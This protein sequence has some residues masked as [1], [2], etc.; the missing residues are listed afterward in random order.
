[1]KVVL[2]SA[3]FADRMEGKG[4]W[5]RG[6]WPARWI[7]CPTVGGP[8]ETPPPFVVAFRRRFTLG[9]T[10][11]VR[12]HV[13]ADERYE[14]FV[15]GERLGRGPERG[16]P[17]F[18]YFE[19]YDI[20]LNPGAH[21]IVARVWA[22]GEGKMPVAQFSCRPGAFLLAAEGDEGIVA[23]LATGV[24]DWE[25]LPVPGYTFPH[26]ICAWGTGYNAE[27]DGARYPWGLEMGACGGWQGAVALHDAE[28]ALYRNDRIPR[29]GLRPAPLPAPLAEVRQIGT[30]RLVVAVDQETTASLPIRAIDN[31][32]AEQTDWQNLLTPPP[33]P[34]EGD[35]SIGPL[36]AVTVPPHTRRRV[37]IDLDDYYC[38]YPELTLRGGAGATVRVHWQEALFEETK[39]WAKGNRDAIEGKFF[40]SIW[41][42][43]DG[44]GDVFR[45]AGG[46]EPRRFTTLWWQC[47]RF[48]EVLV[49]TADEPLVIERLAFQETRYPLENHGE[50]AASDERLAGI[51]PIMVRAMQMCSHETYFDCPFYEQLMYA[52]D[53]RLE[54]LTTYVMTQDD[55]LPRKALTLFD[56][57]RLT[58]GRLSGLTQSRYPAH[59]LQIIPPF[60]LW[61]IGMVHDYALWR[62]DLAPVRERLAGVR[63]VIDAYLAQRRPEDGLITAPIGWNFVD[64]VPGWKDGMA[65][66]AEAGQVSGVHNG[67]LVYTLLRVAEL[68][69]AVG[70]PELAARAKRVA[71][72]IA[73]ASE[74]FWSD[75][76]GLFAD[77]L[78]HTSFSEHTNC[79]AVLTGLMSPERTAR[80]AEGLLNDPELARATIY[81]RHY[82]F[83]TLFALGQPE[84]FRERL[85]LWFGLVAQ[86]FKTTV[87]MPEP[88]RSDCHAWGAHPLFHYH[89]SVLGVRPAS[90]GFATVRIAPQLGTLDWARGRTPHPAGEIV[91]E[92]VR[93]GASLHGTIVLPD[94]ITGT[95]TDG[96]RTLDLVPGENRL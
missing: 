2:T 13:S 43:T 31:L 58:S 56:A 65:P 67:H 87:E 14:L 93:D 8:G 70:E 86:G 17:N 32:A 19:T 11:P 12:L 63:A 71:I 57:S 44:V 27:I 78:A 77:D 61:W 1:M 46:D 35:A 94:G 5:D 25:A 64:W 30:V 33:S 21:T 51:V 16:D 82:L 6:K 83:E 49:T 10:H 48:V 96:T 37:L 66:G 50:F 74:A 69:H 39:T 91:T 89:A 53:T 4:F 24:A 18:W 80:V 68:E 34:D 7:G 3:P 36:V 85:D 54:V 9:E 73:T 88:S 28:D 40:T 84:A 45:A 95:F 41:N 23:Q 55:A 76:R 59:I 92:F 15:D 62:G 79:L 22:L 72:E 81:Y 75:E 26:F 52:G 60:S 47:G 42:N 20:V 38:A 29:H 90:L